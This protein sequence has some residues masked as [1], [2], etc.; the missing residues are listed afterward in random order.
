MVEAYKKYLLVSL[1][2]LGEVRSLPRYTTPS[3]TRLCKELCI[4]YEELCNAFSVRSVQDIEKVVNNHHQ[5]FFRDG[6]FGLV[7]QVISALKMRNIKRL[8]KTYLTVS[9]STITSQACAGP[10]VDV[11]SQV[12][13]MIDVGELRATINERAQI[14][15]FEDDEDEYNTNEMIEYLGTCIQSTVSLNK[16]LSHVDRDIE[17]SDKFLQKLVQFE[18]GTLRQHET[19]DDLELCLATGY[20]G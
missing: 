16:K 5:V 20:N 4:P 13:K 9:T 18:K 11:Q 2:H 14:V 3:V 1:I 17:L 12:L 10:V 15:T 19:D 6:N 7:G 8:A